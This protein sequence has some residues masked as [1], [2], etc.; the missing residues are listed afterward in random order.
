MNKLILVHYYYIK[1]EECGSQEEKKRKRSRKHLKYFFSYW[2]QFHPFKV[3]F[4]I[5]SALF[6]IYFKARNEKKCES[7]G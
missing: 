5:V 1:M 4:Y 2:N 3:D 7:E 6:S